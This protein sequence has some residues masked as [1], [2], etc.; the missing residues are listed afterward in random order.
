MLGHSMG[1]LRTF[2][3]TFAQSAK[4]FKGTIW[5]LFTQKILKFYSLPGRIWGYTVLQY[6]LLTAKLAYGERSTWFAIDNDISS[7]DNL[8]VYLHWWGMASSC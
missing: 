7:A 2:V 1:T 3:Q 5:G 6:K 4:A 8:I